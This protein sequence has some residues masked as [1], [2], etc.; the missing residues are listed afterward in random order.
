[1]RVRQEA[2]GSGVFTFLTGGPAY[3]GWSASGDGGKVWLGSALVRDAGDDRRLGSPSES[4]SPSRTLVDVDLSS[5]S[6]VDYCVAGQAMG[7]G[8]GDER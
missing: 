8:N 1:M 4:W 6:R 7:R 5:S 3:W 2:S